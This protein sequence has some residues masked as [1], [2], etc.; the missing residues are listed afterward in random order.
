MSLAPMTIRAAAA[1]RDVVQRALAE[2]EGG[3]GLY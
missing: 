1:T 2:L 3:A